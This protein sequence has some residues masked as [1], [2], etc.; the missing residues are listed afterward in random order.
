MK[1]I[2]PALSV[3]VGADKGGSAL[4]P[5]ITKAGKEIPDVDEK[6][7]SYLS[8]KDLAKIKLVSKTWYA[9]AHRNMRAYAEIIVP[10]R[11]KDDL[12]GVRIHD[13]PPIH[14]ARLG[15]VAL[16]STGA[17]L[18]PRHKLVFVP[19]SESLRVCRMS[20]NGETGFNG[21]FCQDTRWP[22]AVLETVPYEAAPVPALLGIPLHVTRVR[23]RSDL[24][25]RAD[26]VNQWATCM[27][28]EPASGFAPPRWQANV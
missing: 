17:G 11:K 16:G 15:D 3:T 23:P 14:G 1:C 20:A 13:H 19:D 26:F 21:G 27:M 2:N 12:V 18:V 6:I 5:L 4:F 10:P 9:V 28:I 25:K 24:V 7:L 8:P 22:K